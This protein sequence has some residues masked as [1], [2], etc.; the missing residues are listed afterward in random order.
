MSQ[1]TGLR[2][3]DLD[4]DWTIVAPPR[5]SWPRVGS[6]GPCPL[7]PGPDEDTPPETWRLSGPVP[8]AWR[9]RAV[10]N[11]FPLS[12]AHEVIIESPA[13]DWDLAC[14][15]ETEIVGVLYA[16][17]ER[18]RALR[19]RS[20]HVVIFRNRGCAAGTSLG[21]PHSQVVGLPIIPPAIQRATAGSGLQPRPAHRPAGLE[22]AP[23][24]TW[25]LDVLPRQAIPGGL[26]LATG[27]RVATRTPED[28]AALLRAAVHAPRLTVAGAPAT[29]TNDRER[30]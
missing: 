11:R 3:D 29:P 23:Y 25:R 14:A 16:W 9:V 4:G 19:R 26:E 20:A 10:P 1:T 7:C 2:R 18:Q 15:D 6:G 13:H 28:A 12:G 5:D 17:Q 21:H 22:G 8:G 24:L 27:I 30:Q